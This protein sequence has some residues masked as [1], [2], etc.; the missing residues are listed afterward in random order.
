[1]QDYFFVRVGFFAAGF[2]LVAVFADVLALTFFGVALAAAF[3]EIF[4][5]A[6]TVF[7]AG[8]FLAADFPLTMGCSQQRISA[9]AHPH[10]S[11]TTITRPHTSQFR[12][13]PFF[14]FAIICAS[15]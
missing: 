9:A 11:S 12:T 13:S 3:F 7:A 15:F 6:A 10:A 2:A 14:T 5:G 8:F 4:A 1:M